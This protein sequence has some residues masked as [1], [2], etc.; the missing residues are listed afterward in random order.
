MEPVTLHTKLIHHAFTHKKSMHTP[1][2]VSTKIVKRIVKFKHFIRY[3]V[4][5]HN[6]K[7]VT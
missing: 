6:N 4:T 1:R 5:L 2:R 3:S 7:P